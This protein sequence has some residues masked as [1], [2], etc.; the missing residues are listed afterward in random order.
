MA[1]RYTAVILQYNFT[2]KQ[3]ITCFAVYF[4]VSHCYLWCIIG[5][6]CGLGNSILLINLFC[7]MTCKKLYLHPLVRI[8][9]IL[10]HTENNT[11]M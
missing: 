7:G 10:Y 4:K 5:K 2:E 1:F 11:I 8:L 6:R 9:K 3:C